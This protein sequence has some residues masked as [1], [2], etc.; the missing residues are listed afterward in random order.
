M[1]PETMK[2]HGLFS[3]NELMTTDMDAAKI[4]YCEAL[5]WNFE[6]CS[7]GDMPYTIAKTGDKE[8]AGFMSMPLDVQ[9]M[10][11]CW[12][13][14]ITVDDVDERTKRVTALGG[15]ICVAP[16]DIPDVGRFAVISDPQGA[17]LALITY[18]DKG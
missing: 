5:G 11:P 10:A 3:W 7:G 18:F 1:V 15:K 8:V 2:Q 13:S 14:Y 16:K 9:N 17:M 12:G 4:F 6:D